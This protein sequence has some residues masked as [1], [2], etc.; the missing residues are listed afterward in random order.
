ME[1]MR[2]IR[3]RMTGV[4]KTMKITNAMYL[5]ASSNMKKAKKR[6]AASEPYFL[7]L[8]TTIS[9]ILYHTHI[10]SG[11]IANGKTIPS[12]KKKRGYIVITSDRGLAG[13]YNHNVIKLTESQ[14]KDTKNNTLYLFGLTGY[15]YFKK[16]PNLAAIDE[17]H[18]YTSVEPNLYSARAI[19]EHVV[20]EYRKGNLNEIYVVY[21]KMHSALN[22]EAEIIKLLPMSRG[23]FPHEDEQDNIQ[24][25][26][27]EEMYEPSASAV[28]NLIVPNYVKG[29]IYGAM[30][31]A[32]ASE[33]NA[34]M[35]AMDNATE[36]A[37]ELVEELSLLYNRV[38]QA[39]ITTELAEVIGGADA[40]EEQ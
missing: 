11:Y 31:E 18:N 23:M 8:Q 9:D 2:D 38:R 14:L 29:L 22:A 19:A 6:L 33:Q 39:A 10:K 12:E 36:N 37:K 17:E 24:S 7:K 28:L 13:A 20:G 34:R 21:T 1:S 26:S 4:K 25:D 27:Y 35:T 30:I 16:K 5:M 15:N 3:K 32:Y 40:L